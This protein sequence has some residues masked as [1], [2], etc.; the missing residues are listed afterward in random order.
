LAARHGGTGQT[1]SHRNQ[2]AAEI[3]GTGDHV[4]R[5]RAFR[6]GVRVSARVFA[7]GGSARPRAGQ[8]VLQPGKQEVDISSPEPVGNYTV[9][10]QFSDGHN[11]GIYSWDYLYEPGTDH[12]ALWQKYLERL[13]SAGASREAAAAAPGGS[14]H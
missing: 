9:Q 6:A 7:L 5:W 8:E 1:H 12:A 4:F 3:P 10:P 14:P 13:K 11:T 2:I